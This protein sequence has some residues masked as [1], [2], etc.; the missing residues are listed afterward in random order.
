MTNYAITIVLT[1]Y[2]YDLADALYTLDTSHHRLKMRC[3]TYTD[4]KEEVDGLIAACKKEVLSRFK[5]QKVGV[6]EG[7]RV[8]I[9]E[10]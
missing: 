5:H 4:K 2:G 1:F 7:F 9:C 8:H 3:M 6:I 10:F